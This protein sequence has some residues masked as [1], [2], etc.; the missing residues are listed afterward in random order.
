MI[1]TAYIS[2]IQIFAITCSVITSCLG[3]IYGIFALIPITPFDH[4]NLSLGIVLI[5]LSCL[6]VLAFGGALI[7]LI[8]ASIIGVPFLFCSKCSNL[9]SSNSE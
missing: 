5:I 1:S 6:G 2:F 9:Y 3:L 4:Q 7:G 8:I